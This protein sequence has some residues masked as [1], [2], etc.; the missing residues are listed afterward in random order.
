MRDTMN[1]EKREVYQLMREVEGM[2][3][4]E[5]GEDSLNSKEALDFGD[6]AV[7]FTDFIA[8]YRFD[9]GGF[10]VHGRTPYSEEVMRVA[11]LC[12][13]MFGYGDEIHEKLPED[14]S[15]HSGYNTV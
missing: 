1:K 14:L 15:S 8:S 10:M 6:Y 5:S 13:L 11:T 9:N 7:Q 4:L 2:Q 3:R 12:V